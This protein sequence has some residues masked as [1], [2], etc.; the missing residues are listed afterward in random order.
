LSQSNNPVNQAHLRSAYIAIN[1][2]LAAP[3]L[4]WPLP[5]LLFDNPLLPQLIIPTWN[6]CII[7]LL[8]SAVSFDTLLLMPLNKEKALSSTLWIVFMSLFIIQNYDHTWFLACLIFIHSLRSVQLI[9][10]GASSNK[11]LLYFAWVRDVS[12]SSSIFLWTYF[13]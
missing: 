1:I 5:L 12:I 8:M 13:V 6:I 3:V 4:L 11:S 7:I 10:K 2:I 9:L